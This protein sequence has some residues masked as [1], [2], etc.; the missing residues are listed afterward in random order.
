M[1]FKAAF[2]AMRKDKEG[3]I[4]L[5]LVVP[6]TEA[7]KMIEIPAE[8]EL[9]VEIHPQEKRIYGSQEDNQQPA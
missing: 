4:K 8:T 9:E 5:T 7:G 1:K 2:W 6:S 3:E